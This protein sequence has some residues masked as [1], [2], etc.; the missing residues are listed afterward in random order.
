MKKMMIRL[1]VIASMKIALWRMKIRFFLYTTKCGT[2]NVF[3]KT[4]QKLTKITDNQNKKT[5]KIVNMEVD[6]I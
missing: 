1:V 6:K 2:K 5:V 3:R 4:I